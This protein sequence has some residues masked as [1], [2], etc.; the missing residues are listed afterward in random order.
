MSLSPSP[1]SRCLL[2][3]ALGFLTT[4]CAPTTRLSPAPPAECLQPV[5]TQPC[6]LRSEFANLELPDQAAMIL[7]CEVVNG[8]I[9]REWARKH[10]CLVE[11]FT[12][13]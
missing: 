8:A 6:V 11:A 3:L 9:R 13:R 10:G 2:A 1:A 5:V 4:S 12:A 7:A